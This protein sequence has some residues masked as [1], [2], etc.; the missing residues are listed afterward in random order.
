MVGE[1]DIWVVAAGS[2]HGAFEL[3]GHDDL[4]YA[5]EEREGAYMGAYPVGDLLR[6]SGLGVGVIGCPQDGDKYLCLTELAGVWIYDGDGGSGVIDKQRVVSASL[7]NRAFTLLILL[8]DC[9]Y[10]VYRGRL[11][12]YSSVTC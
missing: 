10:S 11:G 4:G 9:G 1:I 7:R 2:G 8:V 12:P 3:V 6:P 5:S